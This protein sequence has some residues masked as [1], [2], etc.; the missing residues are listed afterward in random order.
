MAA[1][2]RL[3]AR[4]EITHDDARAMQRLVLDALDRGPLTQQA[5]FARARAGA[6]RRV[7]RSL[8]FAWSA[9]RPSIVEGVI[10]YGPPRGPATAR[11]FVKWSGIP[12]GEARPIWQSL[13]GE[14]ADVSIEGAQASVLATDLPAIRKA[15]PKDETVRLLPAFDAFLLAHAAKDHMVDPRFYKRVYRSQGWLSP[16]VLA[17]GRIVAVWSLQRQT[18]TI[19]PFER[20]SKGVRR[21]IEEEIGALSGFLNAPREGAI[22]ARLRC[23]RSRRNAGT[24]L[25]ALPHAR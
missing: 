20:L 6:S 13:A 24:G 23:V 14:L 12:A 15:Q 25:A 10:C 18:V 3:L 4:L 8:R 7:Q 5:L 16:V 17:G 9:F 2:A 1:L 11:D 22:R 21:G 19:E